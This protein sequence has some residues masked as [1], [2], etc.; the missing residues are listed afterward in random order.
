MIDK[1]KGIFGPKCT[2]INVNGEINEFI[3][4]PSKQMKFCEAVDYSFNLPLRL[5]PEN[6][7]CPGARRCTGFDKDDKQLAGAISANNN[8]PVHFIQNTL[9]DISK[10]H[11]I[12]HINLG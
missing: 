10:L 7:G 1:L 2:A 11:S 6:L 8:I 12:R 3:N 4:I 9:G 5:N